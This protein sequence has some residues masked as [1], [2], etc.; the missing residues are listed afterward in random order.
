MPTTG[1]KKAP[2]SGPAQKSPVDPSCSPQKEKAG[3]SKEWDQKQMDAK[4]EAEAARNKGKEAS[5]SFPKK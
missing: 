1:S 5:G 4:K 3:A 2:S